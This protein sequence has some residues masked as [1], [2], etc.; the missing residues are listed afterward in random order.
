[1]WRS[2]VRGQQ[3]F[4]DIAADHVSAHA[5]DD[6]GID[7]LRAA[8][9]MK[10]KVGDCLVVTEKTLLGD[11][12]V[13]LVHAFDLIR[14]HSFAIVDIGTDGDGT[15][16][17]PKDTAAPAEPWRRRRIVGCEPPYLLSDGFGCV[18]LAPQF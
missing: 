3:F 18:V 15:P 8:H 13:E 10:C 11:F 1:M 12:G 16:A 9:V 2:V 14:H 17:L 4:M 5:H 7:G 6:T